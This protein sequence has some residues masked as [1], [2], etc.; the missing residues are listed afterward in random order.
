MYL[1]FS[2][3]KKFSKEVYIVAADFADVWLDILKKL[4]TDI[5]YKTIFK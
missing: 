2:R 3:E 1:Y 5:D 4:S